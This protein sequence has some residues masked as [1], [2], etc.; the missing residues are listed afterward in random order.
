M[1]T[2]QSL[3]ENG[4]ITYMRTDSTNLAAVAVEAARD[5]VRSE[6][7]TAY[8]AGGTARL[9]VKS[10]KRAGGPRGDSAR[11]ASVPRSRRR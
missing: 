8:P 1:S 3:Y 9:Q 2:A 6:Y 11:R 5:L 4:Y 7:G 10:E